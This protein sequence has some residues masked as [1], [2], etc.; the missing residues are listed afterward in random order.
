MFKNFYAMLPI[1][2]GHNVRY[3]SEK[4]TYIGGGGIVLAI[5]Q[6]KTTAAPPVYS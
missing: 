6:I 5:V 3:A 1:F 4:A 2:G